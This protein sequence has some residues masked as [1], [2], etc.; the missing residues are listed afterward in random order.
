MKMGNLSV[1][2]REMGR[3]ELKL[4]AQAKNADKMHF[5]GWQAHLKK[6]SFLQNESSLLIDEERT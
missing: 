1:K 3:N 4:G 2:A 6:S 5:F